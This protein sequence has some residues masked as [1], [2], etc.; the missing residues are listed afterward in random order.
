MKKKNKKSSARRRAA[1]EDDAAKEA[2][3]DELIALKAIFEEDLVLHNNEHGFT[4]RVVP[5]PG[6]AQVNYVSVE[7]E[8]K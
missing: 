2:A 6:E 8:V 4:L 7:L 5:H 3:A 1:A